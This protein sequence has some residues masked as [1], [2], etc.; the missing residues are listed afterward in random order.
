MIV[1]SH[2]MLAYWGDERVGEVSEAAFGVVRVLGVD[3]ELGV[4]E[5][6]GGKKS[7]D[8]KIWWEIRMDM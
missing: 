2:K 7:R 6:V 3:E 1:V 4:S 8:E 5:R